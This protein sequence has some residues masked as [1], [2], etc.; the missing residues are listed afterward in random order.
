M[1]KVI[2]FVKSYAYD[3]ISIDKILRWDRCSGS[4]LI[5]T[6]GFAPKFMSGVMEC[7][8]FNWA[9]DLG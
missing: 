2:N 6:H 4:L 8:A 7:H 3:F 1:L 9:I 5:P